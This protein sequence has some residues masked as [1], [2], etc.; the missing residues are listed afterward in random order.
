MPELPEVQ[1]IVSDL[2]KILVGRKITDVWFDA[3]NLVKYPRPDLFK[4]EIRDAKILGVRRRAKNI[5]I[6][7][8]KD[9]TLLIH[10]KMT[11]HLLIGK[12]IIK[13]GRCG[14]VEPP[15]IKEKIN[16]YIHLLLW[17]DREKMIGL[18]DVRKFA[19]VLL[20]NKNIINRELAD[21]GPEPLESSFSF[22]VFNAL[23]DS[24]KK[25]IKQVLMD[26]TVISGIGNIYSDDILWH[27]GVHP[28]RSA[29]YLNLGEK[30]R[31]WQSI[32]I[33]LKKAIKSRGA[34]ISD[35]RDISG[36]K[37]KYQNIRLV[38]GRYKE[39]CKRCSGLIEKVK[40]GGRTS[41]FCPKCQKL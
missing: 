14:A 7:L 23:I 37:G 31:I 22:T 41:C 10:L 27:A 11:G 17:L 28:L 20:G 3:F 12:W 25:S 32:K 24:R 16:N 2:S 40:I 13:D 21:L 36:K 39:G 6:D 33:I 15:E 35:Y 18:S 1:T 5:L 8:D 30:K 38:Y 29:K 26:Q 34:S 19:K 4:K 9:R